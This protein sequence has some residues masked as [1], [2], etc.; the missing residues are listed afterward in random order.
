MINDGTI[1]EVIGILEYEKW[2]E[3]NMKDD[4]GYKVKYRPNPTI[5]STN[6]EAFVLNGVSTI[7]KINGQFYVDRVHVSKDATSKELYDI[8]TEMIKAFRTNDIMRGL[9]IHVL[10]FEMPGYAQKY[11]RPVENDTTIFELRLFAKGYP[12]DGI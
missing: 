2:L 6:T 12:K 8:M 1:K 9:D 5:V 10:S 4:Y 11:L 7:D 3:Y